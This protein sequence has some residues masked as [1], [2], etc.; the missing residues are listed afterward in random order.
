ML[1]MIK[2]DIIFVLLLITYC[3]G[4]NHQRKHIGFL[5]R[6][7]EYTLPVFYDL[8]NDDETDWREQSNLKF[9]KSLSL[10]TSYKDDNK[11]HR[12]QEGEDIWAY[13]NWFYGMTG[14]TIFES[15]SL[16]GFE[17]STSLMF[18]KF[19]N[20][21]SIHVEANRNSFGR[22]LKNRPHSINIHA[23]LC[24]KTET[25]H[26]VSAQNPAVSGV[27]EFMSENFKSVWHH[28]LHEG[29]KSGNISIHELPTVMC[30]KLSSIFRAIHLHHID[31][32]ILDVE[33]AELSVFN[34]LNFEKVHIN[35]I[36]TECEN[37]RGDND[38][39]TIKLLESKGFSCEK[40]MRNCMCIHNAFTPSSKE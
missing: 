5:D 12:A 40:I 3:N 27:Y 16:D 13:E 39:S 31:L 37:R 8:S 19:A 4:N 26:Y 6:L 38:E 34:G 11:I 21:N 35:T 22:L 33:G 1:N 25:L 17:F 10:L 14:G 2:V 30:S 7:H 36:L 23:A 28:D 15:G 20:W 18:E 29:I 24:N 32:F 9:N